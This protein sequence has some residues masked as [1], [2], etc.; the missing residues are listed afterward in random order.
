MNVGTYHTLE[1]DRLTTP[2]AFLTD[3]ETDVLLPTKYIPR[4]TK[5]GDQLKVFVYRDSEDRIICTTQTPYALVN[6][7]AYLKVKDASNVG[8]FLDWGIDKDL[9]VPF[10][11]QNNKLRKGQWCLV[12]LFLDEKTDRLAATA[13]VVKYFKRDITVEEGQEVDLLI[14]NTTDLGVNVVINN[15][16]RGL[17][18]ESELFHDVL[19][20]DR[21][22]GY[23]KALRED[24]KIDVSLRKEGLENLEIGAQQ[25]IDELNKNDGHL[26]LHDKSDPDDIQSM[27]QM[28]K[29]NFKRSVG[30]LYKK[31]LIKLVDGGI[32][33]TEK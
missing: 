30:I 29:K 31:K 27:L 26:P 13:K 33:L 19:E 1:V 16:H 23:I 21:I 32:Q 8:A 12:Y 20:G 28:S 11:E 2:G 9:L 6:E 10:R 15:S 5:E 4:G 18:Y 17:I 3:G 14:A 24:G 7:F 22:K 25:I